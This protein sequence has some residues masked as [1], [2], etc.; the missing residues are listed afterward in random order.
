MIAGPD[1][2]MIEYSVDGEANKELDLFT[3]L[4]KVKQAQLNYTN[5]S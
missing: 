2:G 3:Q 1:A 5:G 4:S